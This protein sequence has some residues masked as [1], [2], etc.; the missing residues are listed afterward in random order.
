[1]AKENDLSDENYF[2]ANVLPSLE[3][4][5]DID[6]SELL[7]LIEI[8]ATPTLQI[9]LSEINNTFLMFT[10][11][12][13]Y[14]NFIIENSEE[15]NHVEFLKNEVLYKVVRNRETEK[16]ILEQIVVSPSQLRKTKKRILLRF[17]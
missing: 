15:N 14:E 12:W 3:Q 17:V 10:P 16:A 7:K 4:S 5:H 1:L 6:K 11:Q 2:I 8:E 9:Y 13:N